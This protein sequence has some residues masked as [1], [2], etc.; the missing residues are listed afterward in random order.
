MKCSY[1]YSNE[2][3]FIPD[4]VEIID[5]KK[6][7]LNKCVHCGYRQNLSEGIFIKVTK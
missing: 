5:G 3:A 2:H 6:Y 4:G 7:P 1:S